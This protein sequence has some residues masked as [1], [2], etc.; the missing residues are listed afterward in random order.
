MNKV[1]HNCKHKSLGKI[2]Q[3]GRLNVDMYMRVRNLED[4]NELC[5]ALMKITN[6]V[7]GCG[8]NCC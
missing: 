6:W 5:T 7:N 8:V 3:V 1:V 2:K 4:L